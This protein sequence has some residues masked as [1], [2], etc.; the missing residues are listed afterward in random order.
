MVGIL[1]SIWSVVGGTRSVVGGTRSVVGGWSVG[2]GF[3]L[4]PHKG[5]NGAWETSTSMYEP[6]K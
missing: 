6:I 4:R 2:G 3:V 1:S 5:I